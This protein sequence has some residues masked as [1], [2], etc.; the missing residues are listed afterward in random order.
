VGGG[1]YGF[2]HVGPQVVGCP[3][4]LRKNQRPQ[5]NPGGPAALL[6]KRLWL[7]TEGRH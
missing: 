4:S 1:E 2:A 3:N 7:P 5:K 6:L